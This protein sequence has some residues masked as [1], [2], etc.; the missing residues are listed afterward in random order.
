MKF[1]IASVLRFW[2]QVE[3]QSVLE[4]N[5][6]WPKQEVLSDV[7]RSYEAAG[8]AM[9]Y[10]DRNGRVAPKATPRMLKRLADAEAKDDLADW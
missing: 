9:R 2:V 6:N 7:L 10:L 1:H 5:P 4:A 8:D 3:Y